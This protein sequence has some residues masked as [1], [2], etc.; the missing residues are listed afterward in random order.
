MRGAVEMF[1]LFVIHVGSRRAHIV[2][3][4]PNP[5]R[6]WMKQQPRNLAIHFGSK[7]LPRSS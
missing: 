5:D 1:V 3:I 2:G 4:T 7:Q 6:E